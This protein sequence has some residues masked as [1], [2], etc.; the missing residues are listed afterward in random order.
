MAA[1][2]NLTRRYYWVPRLKR[3]MTGERLTIEA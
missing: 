1:A 3:R 2:L